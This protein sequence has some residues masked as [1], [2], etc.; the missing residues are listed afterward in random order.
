MFDL[1]E[2]AQ[3]LRPAKDQYG[4]GGQLR[5]ADAAL[6]VSHAQTP[7][8]MNRGRMQPV[9]YPQD[10]GFFCLLQYN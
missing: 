9:R 5:R 8:Q 1:G 4:Q 2:F 7:Q 3:G 10:L 6:A